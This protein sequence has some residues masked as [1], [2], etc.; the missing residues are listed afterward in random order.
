MIYYYYLILELY[1]YILQDKKEPN[2]Y[3]AKIFSEKWKQGFLQK[4]IKDEN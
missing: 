1:F 2:I 4:N 3:S